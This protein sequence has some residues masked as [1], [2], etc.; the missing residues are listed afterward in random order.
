MLRPPINLGVVD[1]DRFQFLAH[2]GDGIADE[3]LALAALLV[4]HPGDFLVNVRVQETER[5]VLQFPLQFPDA[6]AVGQR[7]V[8]FER[9]ARHLGAQIVLMRRVVAQ[10]LGAAGQSQQHDADVLDH[11]QQHLAQH[12]D[13]RLDLGRIAFAGLEIGGDEALGDRPQLV[14]ARNA[15]DQIGHRLAEPFLD[16]RDAMFVMSRHR[17]EHCRHARIGIQ[18]QPG[19]DDRHAQRVRPD[20]L[21]AAEQGLAVDLPGVG[22]GLLEIG[23]LSLAETFGKGTEELIEIALGGDGMDDGNH[24]RN[25]TCRALAPH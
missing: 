6:E 8:E 23:D 20:A 3:L 15:I 25:Y 9:L 12:L 10:R 14:Q 11:G 22:H 7:R 16:P 19:N 4:E 2:A 21:A 17:E 18:F 1:A 5:Q 13:L 24:G